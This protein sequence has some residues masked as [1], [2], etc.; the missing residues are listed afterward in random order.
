MISACPPGLVGGVILAPM[1][2]YTDSAFRRICLRLGATAA[3]TEMVSVQ[4][5]SRR[6][7]GSCRMLIHDPEETPLGVQLYGAKPGDF[8]RA[9]ALVRDSGFSFIDVNAG[10]PVKRVI[11]SGS[12][13]SLLLDIPRLLEV[14]A[15]VVAG[16]QGLP[17]TVKIRLGWAEEEPVP[18]GI[19]GM[20]AATGASALFVHARYRSDLFSGRADPVALRRIVEESPI[21]VIANGESSS[22]EAAMRFLSDS[23]AAGI[24]IGRGAIGRPWVFRALRGLGP[25]TPL[26]GELSEVILE[27]LRMLRGYLDSPHVYHVFRGHL[28]HYFRGFRGASELRNRAV[29]VES[30]D[31]VRTVCAMA[32]EMAV[33]SLELPPR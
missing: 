15:E 9:T 10:C 31:D 24:L 27:H 14:V 16:S 29:R 6:S 32:E 11:R 5:L 18:S 7:A 1:A 17:V 4:G 25:A 2:G 19:G 22:P 26:P 28:V 8:S 13:A 33:K 12:G 20:L 23:G 3:V 21:P 30:D